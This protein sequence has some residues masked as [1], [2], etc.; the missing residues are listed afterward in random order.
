M[1]RA[2]YIFNR[3]SF[4]INLLNEISFLDKSLS[5]FEKSIQYWDFL[6]FIQQFSVNKYPK[7]E[8]CAYF[9]I[10]YNTE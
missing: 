5:V 2:V 4:K 3:Y 6:G 1:G 9:L 8:N 7:F 10:V